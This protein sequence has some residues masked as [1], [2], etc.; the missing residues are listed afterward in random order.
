MCTVLFQ[1]N[2]KGTLVSPKWSWSIAPFL[3]LK[4]K[5]PH[6]LV[7]EIGS[8][9]LIWKNSSNICDEHELSSSTSTNNNLDSREK[10]TDSLLIP[11]MESFL[12]FIH[13]GFVSLNSDFSTSVSVKILR[14]TGSAH[15]F[16]VE[17]TLIL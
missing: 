2:V 6:L 9:I 15:T 12:P 3:L 5:K 14:D 7:T 10:L 16:I 11:N 13:D 17:N 1:V 8:L 4:R